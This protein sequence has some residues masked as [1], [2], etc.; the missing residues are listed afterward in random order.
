MEI[1]YWVSWGFLAIPEVIMVLD[2]RTEKE[3]TLGKE[4]VCE[5]MCEC[6][7]VCWSGRGS[8]VKWLIGD[9]NTLL[10]QPQNAEIVN[11]TEKGFPTIVTM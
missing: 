2:T 7:C 4:C 10:E 5:C 6:V 3:K 9:S 1:D 8:F 11:L